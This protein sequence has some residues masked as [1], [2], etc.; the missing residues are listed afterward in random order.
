MLLLILATAGLYYLIFPA[1][2]SAKQALL[3]VSS[4]PLA[5]TVPTPPLTT[6]AVLP[7]ES[8]IGDLQT[9]RL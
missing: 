4:L 8:P 5:A 3:Q 1:I 9:P 7:L 6:V 2:P